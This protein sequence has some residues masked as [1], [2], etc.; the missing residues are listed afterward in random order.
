LNFK[1]EGGVV[2]FKRDRTKNKKPRHPQEKYALRDA[3]KTAEEKEKALNAGENSNLVVMK[4]AEDKEKEALNAGENSKLK[5][6]K[7]LHMIIIYF[8][9][10]HIDSED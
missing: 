8:K 2:K 9:R 5:R 10:N 6:L 3:M 1:V 7:M 4:T